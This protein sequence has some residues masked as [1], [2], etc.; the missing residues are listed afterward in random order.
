MDKHGA[1][2][3]FRQT[4]SS[5]GHGL[6]HLQHRKHE[7]SLKFHSISLDLFLKFLVQPQYGMPDRSAYRRAC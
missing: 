1:C 7:R 6:V 4:R 3:Q 5:I 2:M